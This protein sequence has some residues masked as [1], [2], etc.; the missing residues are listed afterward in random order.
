MIEDAMYAHLSTSTALTALVSIRIYPVMMPE[1]PTLPAVTFQRISNNPQWSM[2][3]PCGMDNPT[4]QVDCWA[5]SYAGAKA[6]GDTLRAAMA[7]AASYKSVQV[8]DQDIYEADTEI[9]RASMDFSCW[10]RST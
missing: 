1:D 7:S 6:L 3:G 10:I 8:A 9:Y 2:S 5:T 4:V